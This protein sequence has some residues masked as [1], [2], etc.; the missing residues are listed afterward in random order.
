MVFHDPQKTWNPNFEPEI[1]PRTFWSIKTKQ[2]GFGK[3][4]Q[5][6]DTGSRRKRKAWKLAT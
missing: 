6:D 5:D 2:S 4:K 3:Q 1:D